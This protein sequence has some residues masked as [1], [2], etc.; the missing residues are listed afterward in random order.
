MDALLTASPRMRRWCRFVQLLVALGAVVSLSVPG[1]QWTSPQ[2]VAE[3]ARVLPNCTELRMTLD[4]RALALFALA[5]LPSLLVDLFLLWQLWGLFGEYA[6]GNVFGRRALQ[7]LRRFSVGLIVNAALHPVTL[8]ASVLA[9]TLGNP[10]GQRQL[11]VSLSSDDYQRLL[12]A[13]VLAAIVQVMTR[14]VQ[15]AEENAA[16][17]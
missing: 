4:D 8:T 7:H 3:H 1:W 13:A 6:R 15:V 9:V 17:V 5:H 16:F 10:P 14:A 11:L 12:L 2:W